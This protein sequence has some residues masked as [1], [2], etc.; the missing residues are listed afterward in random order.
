MPILIA[1]ST[2]S[3]VTLSPIRIS[4]TQPEEIPAIASERG[5]SHVVMADERTMAGGIRFLD[6]AKKANIHGIVGLRLSHITDDNL[7]CSIIFVP[8]GQ[9]GLNTLMEQCD[10]L[11]DSWTWSDILTHLPLHETTLG[12]AI[13]L[14]TREPSNADA[15]DDIKTSLLSRGFGPLTGYAESGSKK[16][17]IPGFPAQAAAALQ[18]LQTRPGNPRSRIPAIRL[19]YG[20]TKDPISEKMIEAFTVASTQ[21]AKGQTNDV[22]LQTPAMPLSTELPERIHYETNTPLEDKLLTRFSEMTMRHPETLPATLG[23]NGADANE[24]ITRLANEGLERLYQNNKLIDYDQ[25]KKRLDREL[26]L[27]TR[28]GF[29]NYFLILNTILTKA[30]AEGIPI[31]PG[32]GS[33][34][35]SMVAYSLDITR[36]DPIR[37]GLMFERFINPD[38]ISFPDI[39]TDIC[40][41]MRPRLLELIVETFG[42]EHV[43]QI[44]N[45]SQTKPRSAVQSA[46]RALDLQHLRPTVNEIIDT[47]IRAQ[48]RD[49]SASDIWKAIRETLTETEETTDNPDLAALVKTTITFLGMPSTIGMH[50]GG[51]VLADTPIRTW[52][53]L[54]PLSTSGNKVCVQYEKDDTE[55][56]GLIKFDMLG[57]TTLTMMSNCIKLL[58]KQDI[59]IDPENIPE[60]DEETYRLIASGKV[61]SVFQLDTSQGIAQAAREIGVDNFDDV[62]A[63]IAIYRPG[64]MSQIPTYAQRKK[65][66]MPVTYLDPVLEP[67]LAPTYGIIIYQEQIIQMAQHYAGYTPGE[68]DILRKAIGKKLL[69]LIQQQ[70]SVFIEKAV[71]I[72]RDRQQAEEIFDFIRP[73]AEYGF[74]KSHAA[75]YAV[76]SYRTAY[77]KT[78]YPASWLAGC[79][80]A[81]TDPDTVKGFLTEARKMNITINMPSINGPLEHFESSDADSR[82]ITIPLSKITMVNVNHRA[83]LADII[84]KHGPFKSFLHFLSVTPRNLNNAIESMIC[85]GAF[86]CLSNY[87]PNISRPLYLKLL[88][89][90]TTLRHDP[91]EDTRQDSLFSAPA[92]SPT[93]QDP[94]IT[95]TPG[96]VNSITPFTPDEMMEKQEFAVK[97]APT[98]EKIRL[99]RSNWIMTT[100]NL[101]PIASADSIG[102]TTDVHTLGLLIDLKNR[103][104]DDIHGNKVLVA[105]IE[106]EKGRFTYDI[107]PTTPI[108]TDLA[109]ASN[110]IVL[111]TLSP[112][113]SHAFITDKPYI[114]SIQRF[115]NPLTADNPKYPIIYI[116]T[117]I[118]QDI[119]KEIN[120]KTLK[121]VK[122]KEKSPKERTGNYILIVPPSREIY[123]YKV[124]PSIF[125]KNF[126]PIYRELQ[127]VEDIHE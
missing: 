30:R 56:A 21:R 110:T 1:Q 10:R 52:A 120:A 58:A 27:I 32:R 23:L 47:A 121:A 66:E 87:P 106:G 13:I 70:K 123:P 48:P 90:P 71:S 57:L 25:S 73:F 22:S 68:A 113:P 59:H 97:S 43:A 41:A 53:P 38:R 49:A 112:A 88:G 82:S 64:P 122:T 63:L 50:A 81:S 80:S 26:E 100:E 9:E 39:D 126:A 77:L 19:T 34:A 54:A 76:T 45:Y 28:L 35:G 124:P 95:T 46:C 69:H 60:D 18:S 92:I 65:K 67:I 93:A 118:N 85:A 36:L 91:E 102:R 99:D 4:L 94:I 20:F 31:G 111:L 7:P 11:G 2:R 6:A 16:L 79:C 62:T 86:D 115:E 108:P 40:M 114:T 14:P 84:A 17:S 107:A 29:S 42:Q 51:V 37:H 105:I 96:R 61:K 24:L 33:A 72:G 101:I 117:E 109:M 12:A 78:H 55:K 116:N 75:A 74:N 125:S 103:E 127:I 5:W 15:I 8:F 119:I 83:T 3:F 44:R 104:T 98:N 89:D